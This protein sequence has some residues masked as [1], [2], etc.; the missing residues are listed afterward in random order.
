MRVAHLLGDSFSFKEK[1]YTRNEGCFKT[2]KCFMS[3]MKKKFIPQWIC[4]QA[5]K[6]DESL[7]R[8]WSPGLIV[9]ETPD[10]WAVASRSSLI[11]EADGRRWL[12]KENA[13]FILF[14]KEW[15]NVICMFKEEGGICYYA[16]MASPT[17][18]DGG[19]LRYID[20]DLDI[21]LFANGNVKL[22]DE[23][24]YAYHIEKY[25]YS[26]DL[27]TVLV[28]QTKRLLVKMKK[29]EDPFNETCVKKYYDIEILYLWENDI[30][31]NIDVCEKLIKEYINIAS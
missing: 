30:I 24:E 13:V 10:F 3:D 23:K 29:G 1:R 7:H 11:T 9:E 22:L 5:Y 18:L 6:H 25:G 2:A 20:Y 8:Q 27:H 21:K 14:K 17:I 15:L 4:V 19:Y 28:D 16:N 26:Q 12:T 31:N